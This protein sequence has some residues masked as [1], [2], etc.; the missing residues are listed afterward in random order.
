MFPL[1]SAVLA[2]V[3]GWLMA[4]SLGRIVYPPL[5]A[6]PY[7]FALGQGL[8]AALVGHKLEA[9]PW[10]VPIHIAFPMLILAASSLHWPPGVWL[11]A[12]TLLLLLF[13][14][15]DRSR[16]PLYLSN[17]RTALALE[18]LIPARPC[19]VIDLGCGSGG[20]LRTIARRRPDCQF[21]GIEHAPLPFLWAWLCSRRRANLD[22]RHGD[23]WHEPL[24]GY[25]L[26]YAFL[27]PPPM[28]ALWAKARQEMARDALLVSNSFAVPDQAPERTVEV[29]DRRRTR[30][31]CYR[32][33]TAK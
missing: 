30:L 32:P 33:G 22:I 6:H 12:F 5:A 16:V 26:V 7:E 19:R 9:P 31:L 17:H 27:S 3:F 2:Q 23:F 28:S 11:G 29:T 18:H 24:G 10:W 21:V 13:W 8:C 1:R 25:G 20:L 15:T 14:R 4:F